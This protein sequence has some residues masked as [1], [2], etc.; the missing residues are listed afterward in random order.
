MRNSTKRKRC[1]P[2][3]LLEALAVI[4]LEYSCQET[5]TQQFPHRFWGIGEAGSTKETRKDVGGGT[6]WGEGR[7]GGR[8]DVGGGNFFTA[9]WEKIKKVG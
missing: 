3:T 4:L 8:D 2:G 9:S 7:C 6:M 5:L 1:T